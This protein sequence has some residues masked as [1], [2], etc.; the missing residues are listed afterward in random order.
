MDAV[1]VPRHLIDRIRAEEAAAPGSEICGLLFGDG[2]RIDAARAAANV[3][4]RPADSFEIDPAALIAAHRAERHGGA[5][6]IGCYHSHPGGRP[7]P[8]ERD[9]SAA[10]PGGV[11]LIVAGG[12]VRGWRA[13][14]DG[15]T[16]VWLVPA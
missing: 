14:A 9:R 6:I 13:G 1:A 4:A 3:A 12:I 7:E 15:F 11:W 10:E 5:R 8:S 2:D 16:E